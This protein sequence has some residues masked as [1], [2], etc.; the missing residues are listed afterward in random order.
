MFLAVCHTCLSL[1]DCTS[2][3]LDKLGFTCVLVVA[4]KSRLGWL[5]QLSGA[6]YFISVKQVVNSDRKIPAPSLLKFSGL[7]V[8]AINA[9]IDKDA[10]CDQ[11][12]EDSITDSITDALTNHHGQSVQLVQTDQI[13]RQSIKVTL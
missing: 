7:S 1:A 9:A 11:P 8:K 4:I 2:Y 3:L 6:N 12:H 10:S 13:S 5:R